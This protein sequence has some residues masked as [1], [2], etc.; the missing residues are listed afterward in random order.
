MG[1]ILVTPAASPLVTIA[2]ARAWC[3]VTGTAHDARLQPMLDAAIVRV[4]DELGKAIGPQTWLLAIDRFSDRIDLPRGPVASITSITYLDADLVEQTLA[5]S[6]YTL[7]LISDPQGI[8]RNDEAS[9]PEVGAR[10]NAV[11]I[12][13][14]TGY[15]S[16][17]RETAAIKAAILA[18]VGHWFDDGMIGA[19]PAGVRQTLSPYRRIVI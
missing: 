7:D 9:W 5:S 16:D 12:T 8:V 3:R 11:E 19:M 4:E 1:L 6:V 13:F 2:E 14:V 15:E 10:V 17:S 18:L